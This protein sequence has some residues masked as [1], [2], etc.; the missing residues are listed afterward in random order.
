MD[1]N[2]QN[3]W[4]DIHLQVLG[5]VV[6]FPRAGQTLCA[7]RKNVHNEEDNKSSNNQKNGFAPTP[8]NFKT[9]L[10]LAPCLQRDTLNRETMKC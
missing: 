4:L 9:Q 6:I 3:P 5:I 10:A 8:L 7:G 2:A 1:T